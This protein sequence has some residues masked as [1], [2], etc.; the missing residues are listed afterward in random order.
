MNLDL[1]RAETAEL[2]RRH[3]TEPE[4]TLHVAGLADQLFEGLAP[5]HRL[6]AGDGHLLH[7]AA[8]LHDIGWSVTQPDGRG[9]HKESARMIAA[10]GWTG[11][12][13][14]EI[15]VVAQVAR[16]HRKSIPKAHHE[17]FARLPLLTQQRVRWLAAC[18]RI[19]DGLDRRH[20]QRV[21]SVAVRLAGVG[22]ELA[23]EA[24]AEID[25]ELAAATEKSDLLQAIVEARV[26]LRRM[27][28]G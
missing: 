3:E 19:A 2:L 5:L 12:G 22:V 21:R 13:R 17:D 6:E 24:A 20:V 28:R 25:A 15:C 7:I 10:F 27:P 4:H 1:A 11:L 14:D 9:H 26:Q 8:S 23:A 16:Y 18:L